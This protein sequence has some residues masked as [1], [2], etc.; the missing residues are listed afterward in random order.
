MNA[1]EKN[2]PKCSKK[3]VKKNKFCSRKCANSHIQTDSQNKSRSIKLK[4]TTDKHC[5]I[6]RNKLGRLNR[7]GFCKQHFY[8]TLEYKQ[9]L[10]KSIKGK[11]GGY[12]IGSG[13]SRGSY[14]K[15][16]YFDSPFEIEVAKY[17]DENDIEWIR[18]T[19][20]FYFMW[21]NKKTYYIPDFYLPKHNLYLETK[22]YWFS[23][24]EERTS[25]AVKQNNLKWILLKQKE[26]WWKDRNILLEKINGS[27]V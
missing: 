16:Q 27:I 8:T 9:K 10:S 18:N 6:C 23:D 2:C 26:E 22:G 14:Y 1:L 24:K 3:F 15:N 13:R 5:V 12:R 19:K 21:A 4:T 17:L 7:S 25:F 11:S 20:R